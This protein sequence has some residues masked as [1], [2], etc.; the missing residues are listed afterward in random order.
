[1]FRGSA[2]TWNAKRQQYFLHQFLPGQPDLNY[3]NPIVVNAMKDVLRFWLGKGVAGFRIDAVNHIFED[4]RFP[5]EP[6]NQWSNDPEAYDYLEHIYTKDQVL[7][8][9][10]IRIGSH[11][12]P[13]QSK[14]MKANENFTTLN[15][16]SSAR[17][18]SVS[19]QHF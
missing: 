3:R 18:G 17:M 16:S 2:W 13:H 12:I 5:D 19:F 6:R 10:Y 1:M 9:S 14:R 7:Y 4:D 15:D 11:A 8:I